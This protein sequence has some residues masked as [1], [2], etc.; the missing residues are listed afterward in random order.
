MNLG[1]TKKFSKKLWKTR[2]ANGGAKKVA[3]D[4]FKNR[5]G[6]LRKP[7]AKKDTVLGKLKP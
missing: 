5:N 3:K 1:K 7:K 6:H 4:I 2:T